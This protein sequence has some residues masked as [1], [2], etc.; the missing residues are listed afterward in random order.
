MKTNAVFK[1]SYNRSLDLLAGRDIGQGIG[2]ETALA[3]ELGV[4]R[5]TV[6]A[7]L[8][9]LEHSGLLI[10]GDSARIL[11]R[12]PIHS[13]YFESGEAVPTA[14]LVERHFIS[15]M[16]G[17]ECQPGQMINGLDLARQFGV[18]VSAVRDCLGRFEHLGLLSRQ[19]GS[20]RWQAIGLDADFVSELFD[21]RE[22]MEFRAL[23]RFI[24]LPDDNP[25]WASLSGLADEHHR[26]EQ[27]IETDYKRFSELDERFHLLIGSVSRNRFFDNSRSAMSLIFHYHYQWN[28]RDEKERNHVAVQEHLAYIDGLQ[29]RDLERARAACIDHLRTARRTLLASLGMTNP[30]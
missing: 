7:V 30:L 1:R 15:W 8:A 20:G 4:S 9:Q 23:E 11:Q 13:D 21:M 27:V 17:P 14:E 24:L 3:R 6:R 19:D 22:M 5:T 16:L 26:L 25:A 12:A 28:K 10:A 2:A 18:S 29:S